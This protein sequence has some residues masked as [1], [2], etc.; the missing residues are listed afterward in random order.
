MQG[1]EGEM[2]KQVNVYTRCVSSK[3][4]L[5][6]VDGVEVLTSAADSHDNF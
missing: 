1:G 4:T 6:I 3:A 2:G 5:S